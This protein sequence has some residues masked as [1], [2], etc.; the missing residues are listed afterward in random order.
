M[1]TNTLVSRVYKARY[2][3]NV[4]FLDAELGNNPSFIWRSV[5]EAKGVVRDGVRWNLGSGETIE[6]RNQPWLQDKDNPYIST[7]LQGPKN[8]TVSS[9]MAVGERRWDIDIVADLFN[10]RD[11]QCILNMRIGDE[12]EEDSL[13]WWQ[14]RSGEY[15]VKSAYRLI[16]AQ[17]GLWR[18]SDN[19]SVW[20]IIWRIKAP[21]KV[22]NLVWRALSNCLP[23]K[24]NLH[25][26]FV[27]LTT[28]CPICSGEEETVLQALVG[29]PFANS[30]WQMRDRTYQ[31]VDADSFGRWL[32]SVFEKSKK[33]EH[34]EIVS[35]CW[36]IWNARNQFVW[37]NKKS[38]V[39]GVLT[40]MRQY[41]AEYSRAQ[42][43]ST[44]AL[45]Q[46][47]EHGDGAQVWFRPKNWCSQARNDKGE[48][49]Y[50]RS[51]SYQGNV[52]AEFAEAMAVKEAL[53]WC[54]LNKWQETVIESDCLSVVQA[55]RSSIK[56]RSPFGHIIR[57]CREILKEFNIEVFYIKRSVNE[58]AHVLA[59]ESSSFP[60]LNWR[61]VPISLESIVLNDLRN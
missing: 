59:R 11:Q 2:F 35:L 3:S 22:L 61:S 14:E 37:D 26:K 28:T 47:I 49:I 45:Y 30:C 48:V 20:R 54:K 1:N 15:S 23:T 9:L 24:T 27:P 43:F 25:A 55:V 7:E 36:A 16:Q 33:E 41:L 34:V 8:I 42:K 29:C 12:N 57:E 10:L 21:P 38:S 52:R 13:Y 32:E 17:K 56:M 4:H 5:W 6:I 46:F 53:S 60:G 39:D 18:V 58:A 40:S 19:S 44:Q 51:E 31:G 50:G